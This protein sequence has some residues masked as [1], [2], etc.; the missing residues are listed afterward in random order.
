MQV[1]LRFLLCYGGQLP[2]EVG[3]LRPVLVLLH[4]RQGAVDLL[5][6]EFGQK[7]QHL[8]DFRSNIGVLL[9]LHGVDLLMVLDLI[10]CLLDG[11]DGPGRQLLAGEL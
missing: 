1:L 2:C 6:P 10:I 5:Y 3:C 8:V 9:P 4:L 11:H 7:L